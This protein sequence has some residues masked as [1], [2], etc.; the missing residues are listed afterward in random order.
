MLSCY[1]NLKEILIEILHIAF[2]EYLVLFLDGEY[3]DE[4]IQGSNLYLH[5]LMNSIF[6]CFELKGLIFYVLYVFSRINTNLIFSKS[7]SPHSTSFI[8]Y[9][10]DEMNSF[11]DESQILGLMNFHNPFYSEL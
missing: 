8:R 9:A 4:S 11:Y 3:D 10:K 1:T 5:L 2:Q 7:F 6:I